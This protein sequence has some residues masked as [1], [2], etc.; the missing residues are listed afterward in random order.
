MSSPA[1]APTASAASAAAPTSAPVLWEL[2]PEELVDHLA[3]EGVTL[4]EARRLYAFHVQHRLR[5]EL[6][7]ERA[8]SK[9][10]DW[11]VRHVAKAKR[12]A[13]EQRLARPTL[14]VVE[15]KV[16]PTDGFL[17]YLFRLHDGPLVEAVRIPIFGEKYTVC[18]SS[19]AGCALGCVFCATGKMGLIRNLETWEI[20]EQLLIVRQEADRPVRGAVFMGMGEP[21]QNYEHVIRA[22]RILSDPA[23]AAISGKA[24]TISTAGLVPAIRRFTREGWP[25]R[26]AISL[27]AGT[28]EKRRRL[29]PIERAHPIHELIDA[30]REHAR[31]TRSR[32]T[33]AYVA[34]AG[35]NTS[36]E[37]AA[38]LV[39]L[40]KGIPIRFNIIEVN[41][42]SG[43]FSPPDAAQLKTFRDALQALE[44]PI[45]RRYSGGKDVQAACGMLAATSS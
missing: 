28:S 27:T 20:V 7:S 23:G 40:L 35:V 25:F 4:E 21:L 17:K 39:S 14:E 5:P 36:P 37:D 26:L 29:M 43:E 18:L 2:F 1:A 19:Q 31:V 10:A 38:E 15:R 16:S 41:D 22:G 9:P 12:L 45:V 30:A 24:I 6:R 8:R 32:I 3:P 33:L 13:A 42:H 34:I 11:S 44:Q